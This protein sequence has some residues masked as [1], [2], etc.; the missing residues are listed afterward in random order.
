MYSSRCCFLFQT[1]I[2]GLTLFVFFGT[3][4]VFLCG[5]L[6]FSLNVVAHSL[7]RFEAHLPSIEIC[8]SGTRARSPIWKTVSVVFIPKNKKILKNY[9]NMN[10][11]NHKLCCSFSSHAL[12]CFLCSS[13]LQQRV[14]PNVVRWC[15]GLFV[16]FFECLW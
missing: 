15:V 11:T 16:R 3:C 2:G 8:P 12:I 9:K 10:L 6:S 13:L 7:Q 14:Q 4:C 5:V 1:R